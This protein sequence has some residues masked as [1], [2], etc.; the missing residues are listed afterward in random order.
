MVIY[1]TKEA[2]TKGP[3]VQ[4]GPAEQ[5]DWGRETTTPQSKIKDFRQLP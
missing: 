3:L 4:R 5:A 1:L 2:A